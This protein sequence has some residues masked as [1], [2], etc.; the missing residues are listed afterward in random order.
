[1]IDSKSTWVRRTGLPDTAIDIS[2]GLFEESERRFY[3][4]A[5]IAWEV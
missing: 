2:K 4:A 1:M 3:R 5:V